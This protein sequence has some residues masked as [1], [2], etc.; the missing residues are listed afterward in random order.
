M[1]VYDYQQSQEVLVGGVSQS[2]DMKGGLNQPVGMVGI[3]TGLIGSSPA[4][5]ERVISDELDG[6]N[7]SKIVGHDAVLS[8]GRLEAKRKNGSKREGTVVQTNQPTNQ[9]DKE[10]LQ[11][12][13]ATHT[14]QWDCFASN[15]SL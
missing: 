5:L 1:N 6:L 2:T 15:D 11:Q 7:V 13:Y 8:F 3:E 9:P 4:A 12:P 10:R 14:I